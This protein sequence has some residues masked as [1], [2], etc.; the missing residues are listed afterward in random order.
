[1]TVSARQDTDETRQQAD[2]GGVVPVPGSTDAESLTA[3][4]LR[5][6]LWRKQRVEYCVVLDRL[7]GQLANAVNLLGREMWAAEMAEEE[8]APVE[9]SREEWDGDGLLSDTYHAYI[10]RARAV[11]LEGA[12]GHEQAD[13]GGVASDPR[14]GAA[15]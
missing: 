4:D 11:V 6:Y 1:M 15:T 14:S 5:A 7:V 9:D 8:S 10:A 13:A 2:S 3:V 12:A